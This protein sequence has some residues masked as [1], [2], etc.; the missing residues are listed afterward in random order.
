MPNPAV[1]S[2]WSTIASVFIF[3]G[4]SKLTKLPSI[5]TAV[6]SLGLMF[7]GFS[8][9]RFVRQ[10]TE[11]RQSMRVEAYLDE[12]LKKENLKF[13][14]RAGEFEKGYV[15][16]MENVSY[17]RN[18]CVNLSE[19]VGSGEAKGVLS[20]MYLNWFDN[21]FMG[22]WEEVVGVAE[23]SDDRFQ[24]AKKLHNEK[25]KYRMYTISN[26]VPFMNF[27]IHETAEGKRK[28]FFGWNSKQ[29]RDEYLRSA[30]FSSQDENLINVFEETFKKLKS[31][32]QEVEF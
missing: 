20:E 25:K 21:G 16:L 13:E 17:V 30:I 31:A 29:T 7:M 9:Q 6:I 27:V 12:I 1:I 4:V 23:A 15:K 24:N 22:T 8:A 26:D 10:K 14:G 3:F 32:A 18:T 5:D 28:V 19:N 11:D 2:F